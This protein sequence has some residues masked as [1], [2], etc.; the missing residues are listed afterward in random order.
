MEVVEA[1]LTPRQR[2]SRL[3]WVP[4]RAVA[5][6]QGSR[7]AALRVLAP[8]E[9]VALHVDGRAFHRGRVLRYDEAGAAYLITIGAPMTRPRCEPAV[10]CARSPSRWCRTS[11]FGSSRP[12]GRRGSRSTSEG[13]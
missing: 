12:S 3:A 9:D 8:G 4:W 5:N 1:T 6:Q 7:G 10:G 11:R 13:G 2:Q